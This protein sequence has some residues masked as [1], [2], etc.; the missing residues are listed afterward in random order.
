MYGN[1]RRGDRRL[2]SDCVSFEGLCRQRESAATR[3]ARELGAAQA[4]DL[5]A[6][7][8]THRAAARGQAA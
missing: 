3:L 2:L 4:H 1:A 5:V 6:S 7:L 8:T